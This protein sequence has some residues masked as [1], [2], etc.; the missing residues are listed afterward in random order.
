MKRLLFDY[1]TK[2][3]ETKTMELESTKETFWSVCSSEVNDDRN[4]IKMLESNYIDR[5]LKKIPKSKN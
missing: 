3:G 1:G 5:K 4:L 2:S